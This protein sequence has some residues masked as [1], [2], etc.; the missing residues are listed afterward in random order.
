MGTMKE[1]K[2]LVVDDEVAENIKDNLEDFL[3][4][5]ARPLIETANTCKEAIDKIKK[6]KKKKQFYEVLIVD[7]KMDGADE[8]GL[9][10]LEFPLPSLKIVLT[11]LSSIENCIKSLKAGA[12]DY[13]DKNSLQYDPYERLKKAMREG[14]ASRLPEPMNPFL[15]WEKK[16]LSQLMRD[17]GGKFIAVMAEEVVDSDKNQEA[18]KKRLKENYPF[19]RAKITEIPK[20]QNLCQGDI[21]ND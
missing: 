8:K 13:I 3:F 14:L 2:T 18:L 19:F 17:Y 7:M 15:E 5:D 21:E 20:K 11:A 1:I 9:E 6:I 16:N 12:F 10:I 4:H